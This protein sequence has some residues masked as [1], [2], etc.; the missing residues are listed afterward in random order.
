MFPHNLDLAVEDMVIVKNISELLNKIGFNIRE[1]SGNTI[2]IDAIPVDVKVGRE[3]QVILDIID[4]YKENFYQF[5][6]LFFESVTP[7][8]Q[9]L[10]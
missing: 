4:Y 1:F 8:F 2:V 3:G 7:D 5:S 10:A 6:R 9:F